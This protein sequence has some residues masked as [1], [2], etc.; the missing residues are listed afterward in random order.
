MGN[1]GVYHIVNSHVRTR[2]MTKRLTNIFNI[3]VFCCNLAAEKRMVPLKE[4]SP[5]CC[6]INLAV[7]VQ[8]V[9]ETRETKVGIGLI[10]SKLNAIIT[11]SLE[12]NAQC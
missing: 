12:D 10:S 5:V 3:V 2:Y 8:A 1:H 11:L 9:N 6:L 7:K 4:H